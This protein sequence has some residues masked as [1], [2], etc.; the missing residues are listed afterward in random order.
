M[1]PCRICAHAIEIGSVVAHISNGE[2]ICH[3]CYVWVLSVV[4][5][6][7]ARRQS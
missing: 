6:V 5:R 2:W 3:T 4:R 7:I 1:R